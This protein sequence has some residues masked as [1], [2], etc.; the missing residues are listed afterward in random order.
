MYEG[1]ESVDVGVGMKDHFKL[2]FKKRKNLYESELMALFYESCQKERFD[3][4]LEYT[5]KDCEFDAIVVYND[6]IIYIV[7]FK[8]VYGKHNYT[9]RSTF[10]SSDQYS[11]Y[12]KYGV[13]VG[14]VSDRCGVYVMKERIKKY[15]NWIN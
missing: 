8:T 5:Y 6:E 10:K 2:P 13:P 15:I 12:A 3:C 7:E 4:Y 9:K 11:K 14:F 1:T